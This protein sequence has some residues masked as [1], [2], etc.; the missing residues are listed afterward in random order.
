MFSDFFRGNDSRF[1]ADAEQKFK[2]CRIFRVPQSAGF[3]KKFGGNPRLRG[4]GFLER[5]DPCAAISRGGSRRLSSPKLP[6]TRLSPP[7]LPRAP[8]RNGREAVHRIRSE[9]C[10]ECPFRNGS[11]ETARGFAKISRGLL[12]VFSPG[13]HDRKTVGRN[14]TVSVP[15]DRTTRGQ[16]KLGET[17]LHGPRLPL[18]AK[19]P[20]PEKPTRP[21]SFA[22]KREKLRRR[23]PPPPRP[24]PTTRPDARRSSEKHCRHCPVSDF[25][26][27]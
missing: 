5:D 14:E 24:G 17:P 8:P 2:Q 11:P 19:L 22:T 16:A 21:F 20:H 9:C 4:T 3:V 6:G 13:D 10:E 26:S 25:R 23:D 1:V 12:F 7:Y 27:R 15:S 18:P